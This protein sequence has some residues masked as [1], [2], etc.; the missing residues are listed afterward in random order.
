[1]IICTEWDQDQ[2]VVQ[3]DLEADL[4]AFMAD[5]TA[6]MASADLSDQAH[7]AL[8]ALM[9]LMDLMDLMVFMADLTALTAVDQDLTVADR[10]HMVIMVITMA[11]L[12]TD[13]VAEDFSS[14]H[15]SREAGERLRAIRTQA[16][17]KHPMIAQE[18]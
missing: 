16:L 8:M 14:S 13:Q 2:V 18:Q 9:D 17:R 15:F 7:T 6:L 4:T 10:A 3:A 5:L 11:I 12:A 1:M